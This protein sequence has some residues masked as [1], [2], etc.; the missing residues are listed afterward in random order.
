MPSRAAA[1]F[2]MVSAVALMSA[3]ASARLPDFSS[4]RASALAAA[5]FA[6]ASVSNLLHASGMGALKEFFSK[7][8]HAAF[9]QR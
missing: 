1:F 5:N 9:D 2:Q 4:L 7:C 8:F 6:T 3:I